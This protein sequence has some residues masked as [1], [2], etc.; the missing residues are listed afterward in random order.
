MS[1]FRTGTHSTRVCLIALA[2]GLAASASAQPRT[3]RSTTE[4]HVK[5]DR[6]GDFQAAIKEFNSILKK[7]SSE[8]AYTVW[9]AA[10][11]P[12][13]YLRVQHYASWSELDTP[14]EPAEG[15]SR[16]S[17]PYWFPYSRL[18]GILESYH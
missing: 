15:A 17:Q 8:N 5:A 4:F 12:L 10:T 16:G 13:V 9:A 3:L 14:Q 7:G 1:F 6:V 11:G 18:H 2:A